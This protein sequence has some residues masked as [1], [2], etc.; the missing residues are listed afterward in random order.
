M[1]FFPLEIP[2]AFRIE[3][4]RREDER[5]F[6]ART[7]CVNEFSGQGLVTAF[8]QHSASFNRH[9]GTLRGLHYQVGPHVEVKLVRCTAGAVF[10]VLVDLRRSSPA[11]GRWHGEVLSA[12]NHVMLYIPTGCAHG[13]QALKDAT[14]LYY[15]ITPDYAAEAARGVAYDDPAIDIA[16]PLSDAILSP[17][18]RSRPRLA[19]AETFA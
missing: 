14:E 3:V 9:K 1:R 17:A 10:D 19:D 12:D 6:L 15:E 5:G 16:W 4:E 18:D 13:F 7:F 8:R 2:G 11:F